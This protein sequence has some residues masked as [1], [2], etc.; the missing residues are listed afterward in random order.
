MTKM[1]SMTLIILAAMLLS[2]CAQLLPVAPTVTPTPLPPTWTPLPPTATAIPT[3]TPTST[4]SYAPAGLGPTGF[5]AD[6]NPL[7]GL[8]PANPGLLNRRPLAIK[9]ENLPR[10]DRPQWGLNAADI[11]YEYYTEQGTTRFISI[12]Y[13]DDAAMVGPIRSA[14]LFDVNVVQMYKATF[15]FGSAWS[16]VF[17]RLLNQDFYNRLIIESTYSKPAVYRFDPTG[18]NFL[19]CN[20]TLMGQVNKNYGIPDT[21]QNLDGMFFKLDVPAGGQPADSVYT[22]YSAA[23]YNRWDYDPTIGKYKRFSD[24]DNAAEV[25]NE[26]YGALVDRSTNQQIT[27]DNVVIIFVQHDVI[28]KTS[29]TEVI[30][31]PLLGNGIAYIARGGQ[32]YQVTWSRPNRDSVLTLQNADGTPFPFEPGN[33]WFEVMGRNSQAGQQGTNSWRFLHLIP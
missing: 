8:V 11:T 25:A 1:R 22:R 17:N 33:T 5:P 20:T 29:E 28:I 13:G 15:I 10:G 7:T 2:A 14:R 23:I 18:K 30:D 6:V 32:I 27:A 26:K 3:V 4:P 9:I 21:K 12:F 24:T 19:I 31:V 16:F